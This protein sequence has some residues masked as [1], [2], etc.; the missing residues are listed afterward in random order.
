MTDTLIVYGTQYGATV[1]TSEEIAEMRARMS[2]EI[3]YFSGTGNSQHVAR[4]LQKRITKA[5][6]IPIVR[7][8]KQDSIEIC[9][10]TV[11]FVFPLHGMTAPLPV[12]IFLKKVVLKSVNYMFAITTRGGTKC[13]AFDQINQ[14]LKRNCKSLDSSFI[15]TMLNND[16][17]LDAYEN[18]TSE[19]ISEVESKIQTRLDSI[20]KI[21]INKEKYHED[22]GGVTFSFS[23]PVNYLL[24]RLVLFATSMLEFMNINSYFYADSKCISCGTCEKV[25]LSRKIKIINGKP[26]WQ[27]KIKCYF[28]YTWLNY[29]PVQAIQIKSKWYMKSYTK[30]KGRYPHP[31]ASIKDIT[32]QK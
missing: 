6:L 10:E 1:S 32:E 4:E 9:G 22:S 5:K 26:V 7:L 29:C 20:S 21:I 16:P 24:E 18:P 15:L 8:L 23:K 2:T 19:S 14:L 25:C 3:Y 12:K 27:K 31:F 28:C 11:G 13:F 17:K 30:E